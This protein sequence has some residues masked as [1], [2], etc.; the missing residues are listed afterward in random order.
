[1]KIKTAVALFLML[2]F[3]GLS[4]AQAKPEHEVQKHETK[5]GTVVEKHYQT[6]PNSTQRDNYS[7]KGNV[8]PHT[9]QAGT[10]TPKH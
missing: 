1:M 3:S 4:L 8:N 9:G 7:A 6:N 5:N 10:K 2:A